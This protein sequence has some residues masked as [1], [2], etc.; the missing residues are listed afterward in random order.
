MMSYASLVTRSFSSRRTNLDRDH[1]SLVNRLTASD[2]FGRYPSLHN[3]LKSELEFSSREHLNDLPVSAA[4]NV[5]NSS[6][7]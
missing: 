5:D 4:S 6:P 1:A 2:F 3:V 7:D